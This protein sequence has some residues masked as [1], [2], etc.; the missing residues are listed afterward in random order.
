MI[1]QSKAERSDN[2]QSSSR[3]SPWYQKRR[4][5][6]RCLVAAAK[7]RIYKQRRDSAAGRRR[8]GN[9]RTGRRGRA[10]PNL[11][12]DMRTSR[13][14][15]AL[16]GCVCVCVCGCCCSRRGLAIKTWRCLL[17]MQSLARLSRRRGKG[18]EAEMEGSWDLEGSAIITKAPATAQWAWRQGPTEAC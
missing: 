3:D 13:L 9:T 15:E 2:R 16:S 12:A 8:E 5:I 14:R 7:R 4:R 1:E 10:K 17:Q 18:P 6:G 11:P